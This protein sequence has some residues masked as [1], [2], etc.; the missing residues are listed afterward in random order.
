MPLNFH[1]S[2]RQPSVHQRE[3]EAGAGWGR[4]T[5]RQLQTPER[6][7]KGLRGRWNSGGH[8]KIHCVSA[9]VSLGGTRLELCLSVNLSG[10]GS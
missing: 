2:S 10:V 6:G 7:A 3:M 8:R 1:F 9:A 4:Q 5:D